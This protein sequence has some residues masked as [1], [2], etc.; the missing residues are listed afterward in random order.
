MAEKRLI[1]T[2]QK[3]KARK[4][5]CVLVEIVRATNDAT[6][7]VSQRELLR[8]VRKNWRLKLAPATLS[9]YI[10]EFSEDGVLTVEGH[11]VVLTDPE[12]ILMDS[13]AIAALLI[14]RRLIDDHDQFPIK[15]WVQECQQRIGIAENDLQNFLEGYKLC[16][17]IV[18]IDHTLEMCEVNVRAINQHLFYL[19]QAQ[20]SGLRKHNS[21]AL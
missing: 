4:K 1:K 20:N 14:A 7:P 17:Y 9:G 16:G 10:S 21:N 11:K 12:K 13:R 6:G 15:P 19:R 3:E 18:T 5:A 2:R 8:L